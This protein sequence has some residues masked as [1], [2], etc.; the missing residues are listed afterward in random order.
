MNDYPYFCTDCNEGRA[1]LTEN[2]R[3]T[4]CGGARIITHASQTKTQI[5]PVTVRFTIGKVSNSSGDR[6]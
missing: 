3:C 1:R 2:G 5:G 4:M 6:K